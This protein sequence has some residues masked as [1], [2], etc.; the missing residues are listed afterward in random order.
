MHPHSIYALMLSIG[1]VLGVILACYLPGVAACSA[2][3]LLEGDFRTNPLTSRCTSCSAAFLGSICQDACL[4]LFFLGFVLWIYGHFLHRATGC[5]IFTLGQDPADLGGVSL[6][7]ASLRWSM[8]M[9]SLAGGLSAFIELT[10]KDEK[11]SSSFVV[12]SPSM[13]AS[14]PGIMW[15]KACCSLV[16]IAFGTHCLAL[17]QGQAVSL[18]GNAS[19]PVSVCVSWAGCSMFVFQ[20]SRFVM[21]SWLPVVCGQGWLVVLIVFGSWSRDVQTRPYWVAVLAAFASTTLYV[22]AGI[23]V[24]MFLLSGGSGRT[25]AVLLMSF[26]AWPCGGLVWAAVGWEFQNHFRFTTCSA[27][28]LVPPV[29]LGIIGVV[30]AGHIYRPLE[31]VAAT[32][33]SSFAL[34]T[35]ILFWIRQSHWRLFFRMKFSEP[36]RNALL[37]AE[38]GPDSPLPSRSLDVQAKVL[39]LGRPLPSWPGMMDVRPRLQSAQTMLQAAIEPGRH[40]FKSTKLSNNVESNN[41]PMVDKLEVFRLAEAGRCFWG[42]HLLIVLFMWIAPGVCGESFVTYQVQKPLHNLTAIG[43]NFTSSIRIGHA[44]WEAA[45]EQSEAVETVGRTWWSGISYLYCSVLGTYLVM[46]LSLAAVWITSGMFSASSSMLAAFTLLVDLDA[47]ARK[48]ISIR[49][50]SRGGDIPSALPLFMLVG[51]DI[52]SFF[53]TVRLARSTHTQ[54][55]ILLCGTLRF[56]LLPM[57]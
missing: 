25:T 52:W 16:W 3:Q 5:K 8:L 34:T 49:D 11:C 40:F 7:G 41:L 1:A 33:L 46:S 21:V 23:A 24:R 47:L 17:W 10:A 29:F 48:L 30:C 9:C 51:P 27:D 12:Y 6:L 35:L 18:A 4:M 55:Y 53:G 28:M 19:V 14:E 43:R 50:A 37:A 32:I 39:H 54:L 36:Q 20:V 15:R 56:P 44:D 2:S 13:E 38:G 45:A 31:P 57:P 22:G 26:L 42:L